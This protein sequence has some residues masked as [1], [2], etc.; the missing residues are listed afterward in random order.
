MRR[1]VDRVVVVMLSLQ[2][3]LVRQLSRL[4]GTFI[5]DLQ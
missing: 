5:N 2:P 4:L 3:L 1:G